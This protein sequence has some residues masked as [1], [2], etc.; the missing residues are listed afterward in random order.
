MKIKRESEGNGNRKKYM[1]HV[2]RKTS[3]ETCTHPTHSTVL[4]VAVVVDTSALR[5]SLLPGER[6]EIWLWHQSNAHTYSYKYV[7]YLHIPYITQGLLNSNTSH[8]PSTL[9]H[10]IESDTHS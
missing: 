2:N 6:K 1:R 5:G 4:Q 3:N 8:S 7:L 9:I 10:A